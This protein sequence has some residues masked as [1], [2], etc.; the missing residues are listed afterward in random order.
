MTELDC[1]AVRE[2]LPWFARGT[3]AADERAAAEAHLAGCSACRQELADT[4]RALWIATRHLPAGLLADYACGLTLGDWP[5]ELVEAHLATCADCREDLALDES[6]VG[7]PP[8]PFRRPA[9]ASGWQGLAV[10]ASLAGA[11][12]LGWLGGR[13]TSLAP[14]SGPAAAA[15][16]RVAL[17]ELAPES[18]RTRSASD[19]PRADAATPLTVVLHSDLVADASD[20]RLRVLAASG[21][22]LEEIRGVAPREEGGFVV[23]LRPQGWPAGDLRLELES[24][25]PNGWVPFESYRLRLAP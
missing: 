22:L 11:V 20:Y 13:L 17:V 19:A 2:L 18:A 12:A 3:L 16:G 4:R 21:E 9:A 1:P 7:A 10:A 15:V 6:V 25:G 8:L 23:L 24:G 5:R 14:D